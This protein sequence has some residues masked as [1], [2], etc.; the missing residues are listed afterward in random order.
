MTSN[1]FVHAKNSGG[2]WADE[3]NKEQ[4]DIQ[5]VSDRIEAISS[6][7]DSFSVGA[8]YDKLYE[9]GTFILSSHNYIDETKGNYKDYGDISAKKY[10]SE[11]LPVWTNENIESVV[12]YEKIQPVDTSCW[13]Y[14][15]LEQDTIES[16][17]L[18][19]LD[20]S[21]VVK[22]KRMFV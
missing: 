1:I 9:D 10:T 11:N 12:V 17:D 5:N 16:M 14:R 4:K 15:S 7:D 8:V 18:A 20:T 19:N 22:T 21:N 6:G 3:Q 2:K 13:F